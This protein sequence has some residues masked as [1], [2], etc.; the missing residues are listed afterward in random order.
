MSLPYPI[1][2]ADQ[3]FYE[4]RALVDD[5]PKSLK[6][7]L[8]FVEVDGRTK[9]AINGHISDYI[10]NPT[11]QVVAPP[12]S[13]EAWYRKQ[14]P[15][16]LTMRQLTGKPIAA[17][18]AFQFAK[19]HLAELDRQGVHASIVFPTLASVI[20]RNLSYDHTVVFGIMRALNEWMDGEWGFGRDGRHFAAPV[21]SFMDV[22]TAVCELEWMIE[23]GVKVVTLRPAPVPGLNGSRSMGLREFDPIW[24]RINEAKMLVGLHSADTGYNKHFNDWMASGQEFRPFEEDPFREMMSLMGRAIHD[25][26]GALICH[27]VFERFPDVR[28]LSVENGSYWMP[29]LV[30]ALERSYGKMPRRFAEH[31]LETLRQKIFVAPYYEDD[32]GALKDLIGVSQIIFGSDWPHPEGLAEPLKFVEELKGFSAAE[33]EAV[34]SGNLRTLLESVAT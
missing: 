3:H 25:T 8:R 16:G 33:V 32:C 17:I 11:F 30:E 14:N 19:P 31:P 6:N 26:I 7:H 2:D 22:P 10:P 1:Y 28:V 13:H 21:I 9:L 20:E 5:L 18:D 34:M 23:R 15:E 29:G 24:S 27:G 4:P 12:G